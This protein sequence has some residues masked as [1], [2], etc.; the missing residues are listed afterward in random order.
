MGQLQ[1]T[2]LVPGEGFVPYT[3]V[4]VLY[5]LIDH[6]RRRAVSTHWLTS[7]CP[8]SR[9]QKTELE[10][11]PGGLATGTMALVHVAVMWMRDK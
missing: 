6:S 5:S 11:E 4:I 10:P 2:E 8:N 7:S 1:L 9:L 3:S